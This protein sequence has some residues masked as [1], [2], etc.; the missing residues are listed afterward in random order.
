[1][2]ERRFSAA[3]TGKAARPHTNL[4]LHNL[5][6]S[7]TAEDRRLQAQQAA[8]IYVL[9]RSSQAPVVVILQRHE[10]EWLQHTVPRLPHWRE[11]LG[12]T[13]DWACLGLKCDLNEIAFS[14]RMWNL[15]QPARRGYGLKF[16]F[17]VPAIF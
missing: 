4:T 15:Q 17:S 14:E 16:S 7:L 11:N 8:I 3:L 10:A 13:S 1:M 5:D 12:H 2:E 6:R 9:E